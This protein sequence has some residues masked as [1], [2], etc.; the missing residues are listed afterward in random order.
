MVIC[1]AGACD[2]RGAGPGKSSTIRFT[3]PKRSNDLL[4]SAAGKAVGVDPAVAIVRDQQRRRAVS[5][6]PPV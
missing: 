5:P 6:A 4:R 1:C 2:G 3:E